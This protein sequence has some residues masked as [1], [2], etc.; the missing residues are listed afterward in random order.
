MTSLTVDDI[1]GASD[2]QIRFQNGLFSTAKGT[3]AP[4]SDALAFA[5]RFQLFRVAEKGTFL[6]LASFEALREAGKSAA[7]AQD[8]DAAVV[9]YSK[10]LLVEEF[11][12]QKDTERAEM[13]SLLYANRALCFLNQK[14][15]SKVGHHHIFNIFCVLFGFYER[16]SLNSGRVASKRQVLACFR[17]GKKKVPSI[18]SC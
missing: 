2:D 1:L 7:K 9:L 10:A 18:G 15:W 13:A 11:R 12:M 17:E 8:S 3:S 6:F 14:S 4:S 5:N 16:P